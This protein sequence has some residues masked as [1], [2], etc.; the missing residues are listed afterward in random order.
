MDPRAAAD[1]VNHERTRREVSSNDL[2]STEEL[3]LPCAAGQPLRLDD[4]D[5]IVLAHL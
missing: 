2:L 4:L 5:F 3:E 1:I